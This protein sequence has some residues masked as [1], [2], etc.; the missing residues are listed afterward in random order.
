[1]SKLGDQG[2]IEVYENDD[3]REVINAVAQI[4]AAAPAPKFNNK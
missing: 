3:V 4:I 2:K 1:M